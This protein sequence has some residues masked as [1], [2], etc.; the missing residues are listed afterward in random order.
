MVIDLLQRKPDVKVNNEELKIASSVCLVEFS[1]FKS[2]TTLARLVLG[3][4]WMALLAVLIL[5]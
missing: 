3:I 4:T 1:T 2:L 5:Q